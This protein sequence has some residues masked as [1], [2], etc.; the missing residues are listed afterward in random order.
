METIDAPT[1]AIDDR[2]RLAAAVYADGGGSFGGFFW[3]VH[4]KLAWR[5]KR[6]SWKHETAMTW[7]GVVSA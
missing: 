2:V 1:L 7:N 5:L 6:R 4:G 3:L